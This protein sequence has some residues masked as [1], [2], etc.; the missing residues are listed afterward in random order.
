MQ[1]NKSK[2]TISQ[3]IKDKK[4][5][6][7][8]VMTE[9]KEKYMDKLQQKGQQVKHASILAQTQYKLMKGHLKKQLIGIKV[10]IFIFKNIKSKF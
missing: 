8:N 7:I 9:K 5:Q 6:I 2:K 10:L 4:N 1:H 3:G